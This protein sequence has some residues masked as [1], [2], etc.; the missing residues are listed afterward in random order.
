MTLYSKSIILYW[1]LTTVRWLANTFF[2]KKAKEDSTVSLPP[3]WAL[4]LGLENR[5]YF[6]KHQESEDWVLERKYA[7]WAY[8]SYLLLLKFKA[9]HWF[10]S[11]KASFPWAYILKTCKKQTKLEKTEAKWRRHKGA[12]FPKRTKGHPC[13]D[14]CVRV[15][16]VHAGVCS[17]G[18]HPSFPVHTLIT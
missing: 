14:T 8:I 18:Q 15:L 7:K 4:Q 5:T 16:T 13:Q 6:H 10:S 12:T 2:P 3:D 17:S 1:F 11:Y 9:R